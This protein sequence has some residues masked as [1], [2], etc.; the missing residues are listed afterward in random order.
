MS[1]DAG[2]SA[3]IPAGGIGSRLWPLS[4]SARPKFLLDLLGT[5]STLLQ[6]T[7]ARVA[8]LADRVVVVTGAV[9]ATEVRSQLPGL[10]EEGLIAEPSPRDS[11][12]AI[13]LAAAV[14]EERHGPHVMGSFSADHVIRKPEAFAEAI[15]VARISAE[16]GSIAVIGI[17][18][19]GPATGFGYIKAGAAVDDSDGLFRVEAFTEKPGAREARA[20]IDAGSHFWNA[21]MYMAR[22]DVLLSALARF[23]PDL[24]R[25]VREL[26][27]AWDGPGR[28]EAQERIWPGLTRIA[29]DHAIAEP[30]AAEGGVTVVPADLDWNDIG[31]FAVLASLVEPDSDG[32]RRIHRKARVAAIDASGSMMVGGDR[33]VVII[34]V[35]DVTVVDCPEAI[36]VL[37]RA[38]AQKVKQ[39]KE[40]MT[41]G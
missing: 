36:L 4:T 20:M 9:H 26:A 25:G 18:P 13:A 38:A 40:E 34:G 21:G 30:V 10:G 24:E 1:P 12:P 35:D 39:A 11:M 15:Q 3:V 23:H 28:V 2:F 17:E 19:R 32:I 7:Y 27:A 22:T 29:I 5:G 41:Q 37:D 16:S 33:P 31:D 6:D 14:V 8:P